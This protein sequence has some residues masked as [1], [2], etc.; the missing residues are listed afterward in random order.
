MSRH[1]AWL[2]LA[3]STPGFAQTASGNAAADALKRKIESMNVLN[4]SAG[5]RPQ[6]FIAENRPPKICSVPL[7][8]AKP[9]AGME[10]MPVLKPPASA[11]KAVLGM[12]ARV[13]APACTARY[14]T[15]SRR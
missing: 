3:V 12:E 7:L 5:N 1:A 14:N 9:N 10:T 15:V 6:A 11:A 13:P 4:L 2:L 8:N